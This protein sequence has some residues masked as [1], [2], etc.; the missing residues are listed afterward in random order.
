MSA[1][2][3]TTIAVP[4]TVSRQTLRDNVEYENGEQYYRCTVF[5]P[6]LDCLL[7]QLIVFREDLKMQSRVCTSSQIILVMLTTKWSKS[8][9]TMAMTSQMKM[10]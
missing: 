8:N 6:F 2:A 10:D 1:S 9:T 4:R 3:G 5:I 7:Q